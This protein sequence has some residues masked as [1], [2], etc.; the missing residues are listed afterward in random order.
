MNFKRYLM[1]SI[2]FF[3][4]VFLYEWLVHGVFLMGIY[5]QTSNVWRD[6][7]VMEANMPLAMLFQLVFSLWTAFV[8]TQLFRKGGLVNGLRY[9][10]YFGVFAGILTASWYIWLPVPAVLGLSWFVSSIIEGLGGGAILGLIYH[11]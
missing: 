1:A 4:F 5:Q 2:A 6:F 10:I 3:I 8:F 11:E 9:G 7:A